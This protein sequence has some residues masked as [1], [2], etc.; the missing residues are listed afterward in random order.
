MCSP[1]LEALKG[2]TFCSKE[3]EDRLFDHCVKRDH[4]LRWIYSFSHMKHF[5]V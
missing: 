3:V 1:G 5:V 2:A 4:N